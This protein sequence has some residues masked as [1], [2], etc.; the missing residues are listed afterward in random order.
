MLRPR[1]APRDGKER[2]G[3]LGPIGSLILFLVV[4]SLVLPLGS[5]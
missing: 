3:E 4:W 1:A 2:A 5:G